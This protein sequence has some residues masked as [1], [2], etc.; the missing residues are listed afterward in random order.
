VLPTHA[1]RG[2]GRSVSAALTLRALS[3]GPGVATLGVY[4][5]NAPAIAIY[6]RLRYAVVNTFV[7][8]PTNR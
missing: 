6:R 3:S 4:V 1:G 8:G 2:L 7:S 5:T